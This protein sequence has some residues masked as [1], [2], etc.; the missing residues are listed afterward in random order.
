MIDKGLPGQR[1][2]DRGGDFLYHVRE[3]AVK[4]VDCGLS[5]CQVG[6]RFSGIVS[7]TI[8][9]LSNQVLKLTAEQS[10]VDDIFHFEFLLMVDLYP[11]GWRR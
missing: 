1:C 10:A 3:F 2:K 8:P 4:F 7:G 9:F 5:V 6:S 11:G